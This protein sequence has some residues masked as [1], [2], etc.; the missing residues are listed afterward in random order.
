MGYL[1]D[2]MSWFCSQSYNGDSFHGTHNYIFGS[3]NNFGKVHYTFKKMWQEYLAYV[4]MTGEKATSPSEECPNHP[5]T[6]QKGRGC[7]TV[8]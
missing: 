4:E 3:C 8:Q 2:V 1:I 6:I 5:R 7:L